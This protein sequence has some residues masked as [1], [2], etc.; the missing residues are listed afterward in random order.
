MTGA[1]MVLFN[2][3]GPDTDKMALHKIV[4]SSNRRSEA[5]IDEPL[6]IDG[7]GNEL[8]LGD[9]LGT[10]GDT[11]SVGIE[12]ENERD[13]LYRAVSRLS[14]REQLIMKMRFGLADGREHTQKEVADLIGISQSYISRLEK[15]I[16]RRLKLEL[17]NTL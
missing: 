15:R 12:Q 8:L 3:C 5:S 14:E 1:E 7:D 4:R 17:E 13:L 2:R 6:N 9:V 11:V 10:E 16:I